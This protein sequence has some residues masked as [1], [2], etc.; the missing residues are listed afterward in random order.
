MSSQPTGPWAC[1]RCGGIV[2]DGPP[3]LKLLMS[4][5]VGGKRLPLALE[6]C[7]G[8]AREL[9]GW[10]IAPLKSRR[11]EI[12]ETLTAHRRAVAE[13]R[14]ARDPGVEPAVVPSATAAEGD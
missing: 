10:L 11:A 12:A 14:T 4:T 6:L 2:R 8:C 5:Q 1:S 7:P 9:S 13:A 3:R